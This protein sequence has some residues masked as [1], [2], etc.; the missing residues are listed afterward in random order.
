MLIFLSAA[1]AVLVLA[2]LVI[3]V[4]GPYFSWKLGEWPD[5]DS[6]IEKL[7]PVD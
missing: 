5:K 3:G 7:P 6:S 1:V 4:I 2:A